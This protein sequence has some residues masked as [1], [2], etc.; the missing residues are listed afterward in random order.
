MKKRDRPEAWRTGIIKKDPRFG[1][2]YVLATSV[3]MAPNHSRNRIREQVSEHSPTFVMVSK[4]LVEL[5]PSPE[6]YGSRIASSS[7]FIKGFMK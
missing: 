2:I 5:E 4:L 7:D 6:N 1:K 3:N